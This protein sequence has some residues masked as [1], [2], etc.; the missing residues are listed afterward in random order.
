MIT[1]GS[2]FSSQMLDIAQEYLKQGG[3]EPIDLDALAQFAID[4][5]LYQKRSRELLIMCKRDFS[6]AYREQY[7]KDPQGRSVR[8]FHAVKEARGESQHVFWAD[9]RTAPE[10][11][12]ENAFR[13]RRT[14]IVGG[15]PTTE[16]RR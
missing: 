13:Q 14:L 5:E 10:E 15:M 4:N 7:H 9:M 8:T 2:H 1:Q 11:H 6:R 16:E 3:T 12:M